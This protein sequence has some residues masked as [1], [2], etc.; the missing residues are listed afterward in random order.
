LGSAL[1]IGLAGAYFARTTI[2]RATTPASFTV[3]WLA[4]VANRAAGR[5]LC[6][7]RRV[8]DP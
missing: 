8:H 1:G 7:P 6:L 5:L 3:M 4:G 2:R